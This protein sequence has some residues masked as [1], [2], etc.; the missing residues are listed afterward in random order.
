MVK[1]ESRDRDITMKRSLI[2]A[3]LSA[4]AACSAPEPEK[5]ETT[6][7]PAQILTCAGTRTLTPLPPKPDQLLLRFDENTKSLAFWFDK[8]RTWGHSIITETE[9]LEV[10]DDYL[11]WRSTTTVGSRMITI[12]RVNGAITDQETITGSTMTGS[13]FEGTCT[14]APEPEKVPITAE[15]RRF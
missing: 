11:I 14:S 12:D 13:R 1:L 6:S 8:E 2:L 3:V 10:R 5:P 9:G 4:L 15:Q 7:Q